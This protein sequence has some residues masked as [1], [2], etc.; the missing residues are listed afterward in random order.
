MYALY[1]QATLAL[2]SPTQP[3]YAWRLSKRLT[4]GARRRNESGSATPWVTPCSRG[5]TAAKTTAT[6]SNGISSLNRSTTRHLQRT[7]RASATQAHLRSEQSLVGWRSEAATAAWS[8][9]VMPV[10]H[11]LGTSSRDVTSHRTP[12]LLLGCSA[13]QTAPCACTMLLLWAG[14]APLMKQTK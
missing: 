2:G 3:T 6:F 11:C 10:D 9:R 7:G 13:T 4:R 5:T 14:W 1:G 12:L 8:N